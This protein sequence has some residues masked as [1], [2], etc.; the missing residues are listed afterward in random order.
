MIS[1]R[2]RASAFALVSTILLASCGSTPET[3]TIATGAGGSETTASS[4][5]GVGGDGSSAETSSATSTTATAASTST[6]TSSSTSVSSTGTGSTAMCATEIDAKLAMETNGL[7][8]LSESD[9]PYETVNL[10]D[11]GG[12]GAITPAHLVQL[13]GLD[14]TLATETRTIPVFFDNLL[15]N[16]PD[17]AKYQVVLDTL[18]SSLTDLIVIRIIPAPPH[19]SEIQV[20]V[21]GRT[22]CG[23][24]AGLKTV[25]IET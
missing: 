7:L 21:V 1:R 11:P 19:S 5:T 12:T 14:P 2:A 18:Q 10:P 17:S 25:S 20:Y 22:P 6:T 9:Y 3:G 15:N 23:E 24:I 13:L 16:S 8:Y 4:T